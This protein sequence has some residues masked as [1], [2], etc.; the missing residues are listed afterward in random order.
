MLVIE[1]PHWSFFSLTSG[2]TILRSLQTHVELSIVVANIYRSRE[3]TK[4][5]VDN[6]NF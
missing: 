5:T 1:H 4:L 2:P 3:W 6:F